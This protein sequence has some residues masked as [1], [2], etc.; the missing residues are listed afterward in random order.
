MRPSSRSLALISAW[1]LVPMLI[2]MCFNSL[3]S[4][5]IPLIAP[6][7][8]EGDCPEK[9]VIRSPTIGIDQLTS[10]KPKAAKAT[11]F[12]DARAADAYARGHLKNARSIPYSFVDPVDQQR[13]AKLKKWR[14][15]IVYCDS[16]GDKLAGLL[17]E[18]MRKMQL[19]QVQVLRG[20]WNQLKKKWRIRLQIVEEDQAATSDDDDEMK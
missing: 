20:G 19:R 12:V 7:S 11:L 17:A 13:A 2:G 18:Q 6:F 10:A 1:L 8:Y 15:I 5:G 16:P 14:L 3:R 4:S 9:W